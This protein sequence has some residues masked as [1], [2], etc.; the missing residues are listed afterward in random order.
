MRKLLLVVIVL[1]GSP[2]YAKLLPGGAEENCRKNIT[3][4]R[5]SLSLLKDIPSD[6]TLLKFCENNITVIDKN[7][8]KSFTELERLILDKNPHLRFPSNGSTF[9]QQETLTDFQC[10]RCGVDKIFNRS[11]IGMPRMEQINLTENKIYQIESNA[12]QQNRNLRVIILRSNLLKRIPR[13]MLVNVNEIQT[14]D[15]SHNGN[16]ATEDDQP[17][18]ISDALQV[19][20]CDECGFE[21]VYEKTFSELFNLSKLYLRKN[22]I[23]EVHARAFLQVSHR[24]KLKQNLQVSLEHNQLQSIDFEENVG[25]QLCLYGNKDLECFLRTLPDKDSFICPN[26]TQPEIECIASTTTTATSQ[27][28]ISDFNTLSSTPFGFTTNQA[29]SIELRQIINVPTFNNQPSI[30]VKPNGPPEKVQGISDAYISGYLILL[31]AAQMVALGLLTIVWLKL[32]KS[33]PEVDRYAESIVN[34][35]PSYRAI[36]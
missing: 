22:K 26:S 20:L 36:Q 16:L 18:L 1:T 35:S 34:P 29:G 21:I 33:D 5:P 7:S 8:F 25:L 14:V 24:P 3:A 13:E 4:I 15:L 11:L 28:T 32:K 17:F 6:A 23:T 9:I 10:F 30:T 12:F 2:A 31:Y 19:L 27:P